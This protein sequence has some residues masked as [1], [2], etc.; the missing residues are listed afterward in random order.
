M[1]VHF[2]GVHLTS[3]HLIGV[4]L[5]DV[6]LIGVH[7]TGVYVT[8]PTGCSLGRGQWMAELLSIGDIAF[9]LASNR[10]IHILL[11][12]NRTHTLGR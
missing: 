10:S 2:T 12:H 1:S 11:L 8:C 9:Q 3:V 5:M 6:H 4:Y 7:L